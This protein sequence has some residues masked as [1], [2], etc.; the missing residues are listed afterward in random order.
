MGTERRV[1][2]TFRENMTD[3]EKKA[4]FY[5]TNIKSGL[6]EQES[7]EKAE[8]DIKQYKEIMAV[9][10]NPIVVQTIQSLSLFLI[11]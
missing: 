2:M 9:I 4:I 8:R 6:S 10:E 7:R 5:K 11:A 1:M 3:E